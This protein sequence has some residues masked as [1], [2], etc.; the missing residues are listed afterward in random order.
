MTFLCV[1]I[2][3]M[4]IADCAGGKQASCRIL[5]C[6]FH[7]GMSLAWIPRLVQ[8]YVD[9]RKK[10]KVMRQEEGGFP[11]E[12]VCFLKQVCPS[13]IL[14]LESLICDLDSNI[15]VNVVE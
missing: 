10:P 12:E 4:K 7:F 3:M 1:R 14:C 2:S 6:Q 15:N 8:S 11:N 5:S 13:S 9:S